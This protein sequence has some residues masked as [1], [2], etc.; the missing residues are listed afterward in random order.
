[1]YIVP[2]TLFTATSVFIILQCVFKYNWYSVIGELQSVYSEVGIN[3]NNFR[4]LLKVFKGISKY[5]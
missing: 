3:L 2:K 5:K 4:V 1:M